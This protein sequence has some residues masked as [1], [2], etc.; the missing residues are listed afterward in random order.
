MEAALSLSERLAN[1]KSEI[2]RSITKRKNMVK[3]KVDNL[4]DTK[5]KIKITIPKD[6]IQKHLQ[7]AYQKVGAKAKL[8]G[9]RPGKIPQ[10]LLDQ[11]YQ[12][13][14]D[15]E[16]LNFMISDAYVAALQETKFI[17][18]TEPKF[19]TNP[20]LKRDSDYTFSVEIEIRPDFELKEYKGL[21]LKKKEA[22]ITEKEIEEELKR[23]QESL[24]QLAPAE[25]TETL[26]VGFV[27]TID[28]D[29][30]IDNKPFA[31]SSAKDYV[32][33]CGKKVLLK[34]FEDNLIGMK[35]GDTKEF[36]MTF[37]KDYFEKSLASKQSQYKVTLKALHNKNLPAIDDEMA[38]DIGKEN[39]DQVKKELNEALIKRKERA[40]QKDY[41]EEI[42][43]TIIKSYNFEVP[44]SIVEAEMERTKQDKKEITAQLRVEFVM[45]AISQKEKIE[46]TPLDV[47][48]RIIMLSQIYRQP[49]AE[50]QKLYSQSH[51]MN[52]LASQI[53]FDKTM[54]YIISNAK[55]V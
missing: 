41:A 51:M 14:I 53:I 13:E 35:K 31:G 21:K 23:L 25:S 55:M 50:I 46:A 28:F 10:N 9:F 17:P 18:L 5:K 34:D 27:A 12:G 4:S 49:V 44:K 42:K 32:F 24:A 52:A 30:T 3:L 26:R 40:F 37:P 22:A 54:D 8:K 7:K 47:Q 38:K 20:E 11:Y 29:G 45:D 2:E 15:Y 36:V 16:T 48:N 6:D 33:E 39:L 19:D 1:V 43:K